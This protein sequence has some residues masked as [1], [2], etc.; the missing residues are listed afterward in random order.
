[1]VNTF[2]PPL[3][4]RISQFINPE[5]KSLELWRNSS[6]DEIEVIIK[7]VYK[8]VLGNAYVMESERLVVPESQLKAGEISVREFVRQVAKSELYRSRFFDNCYRYRAIEL[9]FKHILGR[10][11]NDYQEA[12]FHSQMLD[13]SG[14]DAD[15]DSYIDGD[16]Y[17]NAFGEDIVPFYRGY[18]TENQTTML[19]FTN[20]LQLVRSNSGSDKEV[21]TGNAAKLTRS[22]MTNRPYGSVKSTD[23]NA[24]LAEVLKPKLPQEATTPQFQQV[25]AESQIEPLN[26]EIVALKRQLAELRPFASIGASEISGDW[27]VSPSVDIQKQEIAALKEQVADARRLATIGEAKLNRWRDRVFRG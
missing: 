7:A 10:A 1:M 5:A 22:L 16:E 14:F 18:Q 15:I 21:T 12:L 2:V 24:L 26:T 4:I 11:P 6:V 17:L 3:N 19:G 23:I 25:V 9:N 13:E 20:M 27:Q 8:Q